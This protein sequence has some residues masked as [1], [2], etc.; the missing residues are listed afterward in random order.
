[1]FDAAAGH[2]NEW[3]GR[4]CGKDDWEEVKVFI[5]TFKDMVVELRSD[6]GRTLFF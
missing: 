4:V 5:F 2:C 1:V 6:D 3:V